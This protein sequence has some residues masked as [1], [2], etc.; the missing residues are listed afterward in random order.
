[1]AG[2]HSAKTSKKPIV[3]ICIVTA[4][5]I[6]G[7]ICAVIFFNSGSKPANTT[8]TTTQQTTSTVQSTSVESAQTTL[9]PTKSEQPTTQSETFAGETSEVSKVVVPTQGG[10]EVSYFNATYVPYKA[11]DSSTNEECTLREVFGSAF[12]QG[13]ITFNSDGTFTDSVTSSSANSGAYAV[14]GDKIVAT[15]TNDKNMSVKVA[16]WEGD[17]PSELIINYGGYDVYFNM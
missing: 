17:T 8:S 9:Q 4:V 13:V 11:V 5:I 12:S 7:V 3:I 10:Q 16:S 14:E 6:I 2:R 1:M 15:Y